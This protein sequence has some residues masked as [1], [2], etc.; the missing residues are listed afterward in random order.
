MFMNGWMNK[1]KEDGKEAKVTQSNTRSS[2]EPSSP[3]P[4]RTYYIKD[5]YNLYY[6]IEASNVYISF[7]FGNSD[8]FSFYCQ[9]QA[10]SFSTCTQNIQNSYK[11]KA[12]KIR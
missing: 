5:A 9:Y 3:N 10:G 12:V 8:Q 1:I 4:E 6:A 7:S 2:G 11:L